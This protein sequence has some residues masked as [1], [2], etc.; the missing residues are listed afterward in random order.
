MD[1]LVERRN[2]LRNSQ[3]QS[4]LSYPTRIFR[5]RCKLHVGSGAQSPQRT[6]TFGVIF[7]SVN[8]LG[9]NGFC[10]AQH[11]T[12]DAERDIAIPRPSRVPTS[13]DVRLSHTSTVCKRLRV[14]SKFSDYPILQETQLSQ[15]DRAMLRSS[16]YFAKSPKVTQGYSKWHPLVRGVSRY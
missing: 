11:I 3:P 12:S 9:G 6:N 14:S 13:L 4:R 16:E 1:L 7:S 15:R 5:K 10:G 8:V 2:L